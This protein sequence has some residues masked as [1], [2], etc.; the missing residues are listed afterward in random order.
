[1]HFRR[2][3]LNF[4]TPFDAVKKTR[5]QWCESGVLIDDVISIQKRN[6]IALIECELENAEDIHYN[7]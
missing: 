6:K 1:M 3:I 4:G 5:H 7:E 2:A